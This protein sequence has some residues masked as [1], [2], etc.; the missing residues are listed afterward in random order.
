MT[1]DQRRHLDAVAKAR[2]RRKLARSYRVFPI[3]PA[4]VGR[5]AAT[6]GTCP[7]RMCTYKEPLNQRRLFTDLIKFHA[8]A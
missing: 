1:R 8:Y 6:H 7:C 5:S 2:A 3:T 4:D